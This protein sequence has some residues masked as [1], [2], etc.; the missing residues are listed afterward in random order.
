M[1]LLSTREDGSGICFSEV[2]RMC[3]GVNYDVVLETQ[4]QK[5]HGFIL[6]T[7]AKS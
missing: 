7:A 5:V 3:G 1:F 6:E 4:E 2:F